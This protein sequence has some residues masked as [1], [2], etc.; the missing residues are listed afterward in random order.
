MREGDVLYFAPELRFSDLDLEGASLPDHLGRRMQ[1]YYL[2]PARRCIESG[3]AFVAG[4]ILMSTIDFLSGLHYEASQLRTRSV[5]SDFNQFVREHLPGVSGVASDR[6]YD[7]F[8]N[9]LFHEAR[10]K[11]AGEFSFDRKQSAWL[12]ADRLCINPEYLLHEVEECLAAR[13]TLLQQDESARIRLARRIR[14]LFQAELA[15]VDSA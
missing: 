10:I 3:D 12:S 11:N 4:L 13:L 8:R 15:F 14:S 2:D 7:E 6:L 1:G 5:G 9:G